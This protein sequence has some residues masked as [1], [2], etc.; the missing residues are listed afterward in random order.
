M[1][2]RTYLQS[3]LA[4]TAVA[5][6]EA[7]APGGHP[8]QLEVDL[9]VDPAKEA[10]MLNIFHTQF[11]PAAEKQP[12]YIRVE[13]LKLRTVVQ[14]PAPADCN[15]RFVLTYQSEEQRQKW[16]TTP[17]HKQLWPKIEDTLRT[18]NYNVLLYDVA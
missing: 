8:I 10:H 17:I 14:P 12:G 11:R 5:A 7:A 9:S 15:Y 6:M 3:I 1:K 16:I 13:M 2:R 18:K 4:G